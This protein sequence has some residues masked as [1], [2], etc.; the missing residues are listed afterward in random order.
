MIELSKCTMQHDVDRNGKTEKSNKTAFLFDDN[1]LMKKLGFNDIN[2]FK[3]VD[4]VKIHNDKVYLIEFTDLSNEI[5]ECLDISLLLDIKTSDIIKFLKENNADLKMIKKKLWLEVIEEF[6]GK[7][8]SSIACYE[9][10]LRLN[11]QNT[12]FQYSLMIV[13]KNETDPKYF[14]FLDIFL[15][16][17]LRNLTGEIQILRTKDL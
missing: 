11:N 6:K 14:N 9:R 12:D 17:K 3:K 15:K 13:L 8:I 1:D 16:Q 10:L 7:F 4:Y 2:A 5:K